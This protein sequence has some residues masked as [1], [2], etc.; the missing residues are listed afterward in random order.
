MCYIHTI[1][2]LNEKAEKSMRIIGGQNRGTKLYVLD[3]IE[4]RPTLDRVKEAMFSKINFN[5]QDSIILDLFSGSGAIGLEA[6]S[7]GA[8]KAY[9]C[10][11]SFKA[12]RIIEKN[13]EKTKLSGKA[14]VISDDYLKALENLRNQNIKFDIIFLDPPYKTDYNIKAINLILKY[15]LLDENGQMIIETDIPEKTLEELKSFSVNIYDIK[16]YG[17]VTLIFANRKG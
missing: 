7:R 4:T 15:N 14:I 6:L 8:K 12:I 2:V 1:C 16:R 13:I 17:R 9:L 11:N 5:L 10:D 3:S